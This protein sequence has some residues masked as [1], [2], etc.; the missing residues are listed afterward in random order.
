MAALGLLTGLAWLAAGA[1]AVAPTAPKPSPQP[2]PPNVL[3]I[4]AD[5][6][7][8]HLG[9]YG[10]RIVKSPAIDRLAARGVRF[11]RAYC[12]TPL[13]NPSRIS[14]ASGLA[15]EA[16]GIF[17]NEERA[18]AK[19]P[20]IR[21]LPTY[22]AEHGYRTY[23]AGKFLH[24]PEDV[25]FDVVDRYD[26][27]RPS[28]PYPKLRRHAFRREQEKARQ[29]GRK[30]LPYDR[31]FGQQVTDAE[32]L[33]LEDSRVGEEALRL[34]R[35]AAAEKRPFFMA[36]GLHASHLDWVAPERTFKLYPP[37]AMPLA[38]QVPGD[39]DDVP[40]AALKVA[41]AARTFT[42]AEER[43]LRAAYYAAITFLD[44]QVGRVLT[45]LE[46]LGL[47]KNTV[48]V[49]VSDHGQQLGEHGGMW[50][51]MTL[52]EQSTRV[53]LVL[54]GPGVPVGKASPC[55]VELL[56]L[57]PTLA[58][59]AALPLPPGLPGRNLAP[60]LSKLEGC[61]AGGGALTSVRLIGT[62]PPQYAHSL[63]TEHYRYTEWGSPKEAEL[64]DLEAD[65]NE[66]KNLAR[67]PTAK[68]LLTEQKGLLAAKV[69]VRRGGSGN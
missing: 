35:Q 5:D 2:A 1:P 8:P 48:V 51:K 59:L 61:P 58:G 12:Q 46:R 36:Y 40:A 20:A 60:W 67:D 15:P 43:E 53:P 37:A 11:D 68:P 50:E 52:F 41:K 28:A 32:A 16:T 44:E 64:Y 66:F 19:L 23:R 3:F 54:A 38:P 65:P 34:L 10:D 25:A 24:F 62:G 31:V 29:E 14:F 18:R 49:L 7:T 33:W 30:V 17:D 69:A 47:A 57:F 63:R 26:Q 13:C 22:F 9:A 39:L 4:V 45:E 27:V 6:L 42:P 21:F 56:D 55:I